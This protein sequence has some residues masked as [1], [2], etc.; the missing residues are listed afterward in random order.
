MPAIDDSAATEPM[1]VSRDATPDHSPQYT[2]YRERDGQRFAT[3]FSTP[4]DARLVASAGE[5]ADLAAQMAEAL[6]AAAPNPPNYATPPLV[7]ETLRLLEH[8]AYG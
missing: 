3:V 8:I 4:R 7:V 1:A 6:H 2:V 5:L